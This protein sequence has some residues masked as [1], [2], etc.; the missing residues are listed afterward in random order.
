MI[1]HSK[2]YQAKYG[3][4]AG[5]PEG[6]KPNFT[7]CC[8]TVWERGGSWSRP[9]QCSRSRGY[10]AD[11]AY[12]RQHDPAAVKARDEATRKQ[13]DLKWN[14]ARYEI[15]GP[16]FFKALV[17]IAEGH[18]DARGLAQKVVKEFKEGEK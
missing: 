8:E 5:S 13:H 2:L 3:A 7:Q 15:H 11:G 6:N 17:K 10:G 9:H 14:K 12:C 1:K 4:W 18:N 16:T